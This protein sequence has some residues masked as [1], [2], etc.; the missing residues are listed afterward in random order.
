M[1]RSVASS[2]LCRWTITPWYHALSY[3]WGD[4]INIT[5]IQLDRS[6]FRVTKNLHSALHYI[7]L[8]TEVLTIWIDAICI[9]QNDLKERGQQVQLM[10]RI[11]TGPEK[12]IIWLGNTP[13]QRIDF[14]I[15]YTRLL[16]I[17][18][19]PPLRNFWMAALWEQLERERFHPWFSL[20]YNV[21]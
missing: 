20:Q 16:N 21:R 10:G 12:C 15:F 3:V 1:S 11:Y 13:N 8:R 19:N 5:P 17:S 18:L 6:D 9:N 2:G 4:A 7:R 14:I